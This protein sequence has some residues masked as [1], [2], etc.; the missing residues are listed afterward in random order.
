MQK[1]SDINQ[2]VKRNHVVNI[3]N[4]DK[5]NITGVNKVISSNT[6]QLLLET[7]AGGLTILG[8]ELKI[9]KFNA[10]EGY[11]SFDGTV[12]SFKYSA[13]KVSFIKKIFS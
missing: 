2:E 1:P 5:G 6:A 7:S 12:N 4:R 10:D 11:L 3:D 8:S 13:P 9:N